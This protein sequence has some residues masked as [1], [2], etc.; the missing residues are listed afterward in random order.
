[1]RISN[2]ACGTFALSYGTEYRSCFEIEV[3]T[4]TGTVEVTPTSV[5]ILKKGPSG[6]ID[7]DSLTFPFNGAVEDELKAFAESIAN[8]RVEPR[9]TPRQ[10]LADLQVLDALLRSGELSGLVINTLVP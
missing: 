4:T 5:F 2:G 9:M 6:K 8:K 10:A 7:T 1:M 3:R